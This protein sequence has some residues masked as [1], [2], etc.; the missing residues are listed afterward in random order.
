MRLKHLVRCLIGVPRLPFRYEWQALPD[1]MTIYTDSNFAGCAATRRSTSGGVVMFG[2]HCVKTWSSTQPTVSLASAE[3]EL[4]GIANGGTNGLGIQAVANDLGIALNIHILTDAS[5]AIG[6]VKRRGLGRV[7]RLATTDLW[8][9]ERIRDKGFSVSQVAGA[10]NLADILTK[11][12]DRQT[13]WRHLHNMG[14]YAETGRPESA[15]ELTK[16]SLNVLRLS[17]CGYKYADL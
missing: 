9:Q 10:D 1:H 15:P 5:A 14:C 11:T 6:I 7:R 4:Q 16:Q 13:L 17:T 2:K 3:A 8:L 12:V